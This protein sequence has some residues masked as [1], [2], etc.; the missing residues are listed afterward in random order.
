MANR[1]M[2]KMLSLIIR[3]KQIKTIV[4]YFLTSVRMAIISKST[5]NKCWRGCSEKHTHLHCWE[6]KLVQSLW[7]TIWRFLRRLNVELP[8]DPAV[9]LLGIYLNKTFIE[10]DTCG[11]SHCGS[12]VMSLT[13]IHEDTGSVPG[14][15]QWVKD[16]VL[17]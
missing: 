1:H 11:S 6:C 4:R 2:K 15:V 5:N 9:P 17:L 3:E 8:H 16:P 14:L 10:K 12:V 13:S 7:K